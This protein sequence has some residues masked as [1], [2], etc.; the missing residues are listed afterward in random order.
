[1]KNIFSIFS[2]IFLVACF[3]MPIMMISEMFFGTSGQFLII[4]MVIFPL[5]GVVSALIGKKGWVKAIGV[6]FNGLTLCFVLFLLIAR[7]GYL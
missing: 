6:I 4:F 1:M 2:F 3:L 7:T 5:L